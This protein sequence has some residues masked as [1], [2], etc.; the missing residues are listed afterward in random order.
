LPPRAIRRRPDLP[1]QQAVE[2]LPHYQT[3]IECQLNRAVD[4]LERLRRRRKGE[5]VPPPVNA[6]LSVE[7]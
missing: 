3:T 1:D 2:R 7:A 4:Q 5:A 6:H